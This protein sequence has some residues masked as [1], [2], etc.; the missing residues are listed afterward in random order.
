MR[1]VIVRNRFNNL[2]EILGGKCECS[3][4]KTE[5]FLTN[6]HNKMIG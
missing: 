4:S 5:G 3:E 2:S 6:Y 1:N